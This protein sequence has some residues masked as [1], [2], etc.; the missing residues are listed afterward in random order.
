MRP[1]HFLL[2]QYSAF[3]V[4]VAVH[5][6]ILSLIKRTSVFLP[7]VQITL[8]TRGICAGDIYA[9]YIYIYIDIYVLAVAMYVSQDLISPIL[10]I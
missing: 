8:P 4:Y 1:L 9:Y 10:C 2:S 3:Y 7:T 6:L 5:R